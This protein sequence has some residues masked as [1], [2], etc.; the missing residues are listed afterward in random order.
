M[1]SINFIVSNNYS[2][3]GYTIRPGLVSKEKKTASVR[4]FLKRGEKKL[5]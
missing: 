4:I 3:N 5:K 1:I 2:F